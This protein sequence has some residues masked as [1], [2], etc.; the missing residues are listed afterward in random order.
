MC[1]RKQL[2]R[3][4]ECNFLT[5]LSTS[6]GLTLLSYLQRAQ[7]ALGSVSFWQ[8][9]DTYYNREIRLPH[10]KDAAVPF[11][12]VAFRLGRFLPNAESNSHSVHEKFR[13]LNETEINAFGRL[14]EKNML[15]VGQRS[16][17]CK[18]IPC[19]ASRVG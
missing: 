18:V 7:E 2:L 4:L 16:W 17:Y 11:R 5:F 3:K 12:S 13:T 6:E 9:R 1:T 15:G 19:H 8:D 10:S 14:H